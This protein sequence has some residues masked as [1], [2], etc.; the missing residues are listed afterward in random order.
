MALTL[1]WYFENPCERRTRHRTHD[2]QSDSQIVGTAGIGSNPNPALLYF[3]LDMLDHHDAFI[4]HDASLSRAEHSSG[5]DHHF[6]STIWDTVLAYY[7]SSADATIPTAA[8]ARY[9]RIQTEEAEDPDFSFGVTQ[10][11]F[12]AAE[13]ALYL[14][15]MGDPVSGVAPVPY[16]RSLFEEERLPY[17]LGWSKPTLETT[18]PSLLVM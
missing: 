6:N 1:P 2:L 5:D 14:S 8:E 12:Q 13:T 7:N 11:V 4:E 17:E 18:I 15:T 9:M 16:V 10:L 3:D